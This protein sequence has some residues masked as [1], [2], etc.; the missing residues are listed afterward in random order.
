MD[1]CDC[2]HSTRFQINYNQKQK[3]RPSADD[4]NN[5]DDGYVVEFLLSSVYVTTL[6]CAPNTPQSHAVFVCLSRVEA[7]QNQG[8]N[9]T[10]NRVN[11]N[12]SC[13]HLYVCATAS[14]FLSML[15]QIS[16]GAY[17]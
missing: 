2:L 5:D 14:L 10:E 8:H 1:Y 16:I 9:C 13:I 7:V 11:R 17:R 12:A 4:D 6:S 3:Y 15:T